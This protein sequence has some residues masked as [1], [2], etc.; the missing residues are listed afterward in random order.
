[1][2]PV[3]NNDNPGKNEDLAKRVRRSIEAA[4][5]QIA[6]R[7][8]QLRDQLP[9]LK[10][11]PGEKLPVLQ[12]SGIKKT[13]PAR[14]LGLAI[15]E[16][17]LLA[18]EIV[19][20]DRPSVRLLH[21]LV[22]PEGVTLAN[23]TALGE[24]LAK[25]LADNKFT[26]KSAVIGLPARWLLVKSKEV[27]PADPATLHDLLRLQAE[28]EFSAEL[29][30][31]IYDY[32][33]DTSAGHPKSVLLIATSRKYVDGVQQMCE[34]AKISLLLVT[35]S[36]IALGEATTRVAATKNAL[37]LLVGPYGAELT[38]QSGG[39]SNAI[40]HM[41]PP[42]PDKPFVGELRRTISGL[43]Q[44]ASANGLARE[45]VLWD[46]GG[47]YN[48]TALD[49]SL[50]MPV[51]SG[52]LPTLGVET[53]GAASNGEGRKYAAAVALGMLALNDSPAPVDFL[54]SR[55]A[56]PKPPLL[57]RWATIAITSAAVALVLI[58]TALVYQSRQ[59]SKLTALSSDV[60]AVADQV[61]TDRAFVNKV[62][63]A[64]AWHL[65][66]YRYLPCLR[67]I[68]NAVPAD[69]QTYALSLTIHEL[70][71][72]TN[73]SAAPGTAA[74]QSFAVKDLNGTL[75]GKTTDQHRV[76]QLLDALRASPAFSNVILNGTNDAGKNR[77]IIFTITFNYSPAK[78]AK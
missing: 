60:D 5:S 50:G 16:R 23:P 69:G 36:A 28:G 68:T 62:T 74:A 29:K 6:R 40:R 67:D 21:E 3:E 63:I 32:S 42:T 59:Q 48:F 54:H 37:V 47:G 19:S 13:K 66:S 38:S 46:G 51:R 31:L 11:E 57:P 12:W 2:N 49:E 73:N 20:G 18:A 9:T 64:R 45:L 24:T 1:M 7:T 25:F 61:K 44:A 15:G 34:A 72:P 30:D 14:V 78:A 56:A 35:P 26:A 58:V 41:R 27:P 22:Y 10:W 77:E 43:P 17:S 70:T 33:A 71:P 39:T 65:G 4:S 76:L 53:S 55:L 8:S 52:D 75:E